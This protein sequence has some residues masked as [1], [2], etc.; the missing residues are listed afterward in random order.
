[1]SGYTEDVM[2]RQGI[3]KAG[4]A[5][6]AKPLTPDELAAKVRETLG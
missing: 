6:V 2:V 3:L 4:I 1:M 5:Y